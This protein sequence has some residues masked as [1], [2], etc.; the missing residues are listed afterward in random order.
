MHVGLCRSVFPCVVL[1]ACLS[2]PSSDQPY[3][4]CHNL[5][6]CFPIIH[7]SSVLSCSSALN[8]CLCLSISACFSVRRSVYMS[9][10]PSVYMAVLSPFPLSVFLLLCLSSSASDA[11]L[12][13][14]QSTVAFVDDK[15]VFVGC[16]VR[17]RPWVTSLYW[18]IDVNGTTITSGQVVSEYWT[19]VMVSSTLFFAGN[20]LYM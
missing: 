16:V 2:V 14:C 4:S 18:V 13:D 17:A 8:V 12:I 3:K 10:Y 5:I 6:H 20:S 7:L 1:F 15:N 11:P 19:L 9:L